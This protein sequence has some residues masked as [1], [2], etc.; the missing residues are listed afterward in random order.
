MNAVNMREAK[1][2][3]SALVD[4]AQ[5]GEYVVIARAG[6]PAVRL[7]PVEPVVLRKPGQLRG[8]IQLADDFDLTSEA[9]IRLFEGMV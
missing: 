1:V 8:Q 2:H 6:K 4:K 5:Q 9:E 7:L 3:L